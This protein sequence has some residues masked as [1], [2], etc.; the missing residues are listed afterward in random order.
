MTKTIKKILNSYG[1]S[2]FAPDVDL[3]DEESEKVET[4]CEYIRGLLRK[5]Y[6]IATNQASDGQYTLKPNGDI[7]RR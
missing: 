3:T 1:L 4:Y 6:L 2:T 5:G 7:T